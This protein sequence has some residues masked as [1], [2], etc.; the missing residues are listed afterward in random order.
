M[1]RRGWPRCELFDP[2]VSGFQNEQWYAKIP[3]IQEVE[4]ELGCQ[5]TGIRLRRN[6]RTSTDEGTRRG[7]IEAGK[8]VNCESD[9]DVRAGGGGGNGPG[10]GRRVDV[11]MEPLPR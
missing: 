6:T 3:N 7:K 5:E 1:S 8:W 10:W 9:V 2:A 4:R 11:G